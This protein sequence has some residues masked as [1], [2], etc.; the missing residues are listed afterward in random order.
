M[1]YKRIANRFSAAVQ[2]G[3]ASFLVQIGSVIIAGMDFGAKNS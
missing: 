2:G 1:N 3:A